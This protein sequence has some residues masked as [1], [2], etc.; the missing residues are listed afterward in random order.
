[1]VKICVSLFT[2]GLEV[3]VIIEQ[4]FYLGDFHASQH[5]VVASSL[6]FCPLSITSGFPSY[7]QLTEFSWESV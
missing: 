1:M 2:F 7:F 6:L 4:P 3:C 5:V